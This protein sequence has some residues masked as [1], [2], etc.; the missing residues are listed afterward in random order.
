MLEGVSGMG[1]S[2]SL[3]TTVSGGSL[4]TVSE[5]EIMF[6]DSK[7]KF[8]SALFS[9]YT[10]AEFENEEIGPPRRICSRDY[11]L[12]SPL[13]PDKLGSMSVYLSHPAKCTDITV[14]NWESAKLREVFKKEHGSR[15]F[16]VSG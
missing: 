11:S 7:D 10:E 1:S 6:F 14:R 15:L 3:V 5:T 9:F 13:I 16:E 4:R 8:K 2:A 12:N